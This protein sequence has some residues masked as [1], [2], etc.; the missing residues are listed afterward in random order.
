MNAYQIACARGI[1]RGVQAVLEELR[2]FLKG[3]EASEETQHAVASIREGLVLV[4]DC[5][6]TEQH[7]LRKKEA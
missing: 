2:D 6:S 1:L 7:N 3:H 5:L 4:G